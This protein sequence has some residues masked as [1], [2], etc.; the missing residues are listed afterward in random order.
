MKINHLWDKQ[1]KDCYAATD[2]NYILGGYN[3][4]HKIFQHKIFPD[5]LATEGGEGSNILPTWYFEY[6]RLFQILIY[7]SRNL[8]SY[9]HFL[10]GGGDLAGRSGQDRCRYYVTVTNA[11]SIEL[12]HQSAWKTLEKFWLKKVTQKRFT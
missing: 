11:M 1:A 2:L 8:E 10:G 12:C 3:N 4:F 7:K 6:T 9:I 5:M